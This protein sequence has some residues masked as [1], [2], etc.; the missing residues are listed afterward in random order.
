MR[1]GG[2]KRGVAVSQ[3]W[4]RQGGLAVS[5]HPFSVVSVGEKRAFKRYLSSASCVEDSKTKRQT[6]NK[7]S[8][9]VFL[10]S[11]YFSIVAEALF[12]V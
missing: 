10:K 1:K 4:T 3:T 6:R 8:M 5:G 11:S 12:M 2:E 9:H 7:Y